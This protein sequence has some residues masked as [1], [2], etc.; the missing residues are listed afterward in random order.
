VEVETQ[1]DGASATARVEGE[2]VA[3][4]E[5]DFEVG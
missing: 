1:R 5:A 3:E 4:A 2:V